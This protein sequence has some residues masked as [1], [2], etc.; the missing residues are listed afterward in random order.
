MDEETKKVHITR[1]LTSQMII[2]LI[3]EYPNLEIITCSPSLYKR[4]SKTYISALNQLDI[5]VSV[6]YQWGAKPKYLKEGSEVLH[7]AKNG[8]TAKEISKLLDIPQNRVY[9]LIRKNNENIKF[10]N[11]KR[12]YDL[13]TREEVK[14]MK[15]EGKSPKDISSK[16]NIPLRTIYYILNRR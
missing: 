5:E 12:K 2:E 8:K 11:Y 4:I 10:N 15:K 9:Y 13:N 3:E 14:L 16:L 7:L 6:E 1:S